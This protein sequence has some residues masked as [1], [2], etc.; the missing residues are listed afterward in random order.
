[1]TPIQASAYAA[2]MRAFRT[3]VTRGPK[4]ERAYAT[5]AS[6]RAGWASGCEQLAH[7]QDCAIAVAHQIETLPVDQWPTNNS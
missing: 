7:A 5:R 3:A 4:D 1:M 2:Y 6:Y